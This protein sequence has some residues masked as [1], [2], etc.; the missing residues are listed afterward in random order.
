MSE[1]QAESSLW[2]SQV[3]SHAHI[4]GLAEQ[5]T[6]KLFHPQTTKAGRLASLKADYPASQKVEASRLDFVA[7]FKRDFSASDNPFSRHRP[8][9]PRIQKAAGA[10]LRQDAS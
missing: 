1:V 9:P 8:F 10:E 4:D 6:R 5:S 2:P 3:L 7:I